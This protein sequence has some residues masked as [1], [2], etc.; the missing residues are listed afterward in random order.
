MNKS[1]VL[2]LWLFSLCIMFAT[3]VMAEVAKKPSKDARHD[4]AITAAESL[5]VEENTFDASVQKK[6]PKTLLNLSQLLK[7]EGDELAWDFQQF[8]YL[9]LLK[10]PIATSGR[11]DVALNGKDIAVN[12]LVK[13]PV[14]S[15]FRIKDGKVKQKK[16]GK[17]KGLSATE[18]P[19]FVF[20][21]KIMNQA[22]LGDFT[23][24]SEHFNIY[25]LPRDQS[26]WSIGLKPKDPES[27]LADMIHYI[28]LDGVSAGSESAALTQIM[29]MDVRGEPSL[30]AL[31]VAKSL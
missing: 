31:S 6:W 19:A 1:N 14:K 16:N 26:T 29:I 18:Q 30:I 7:P 27:Q 20:I 13:K 5:F 12:W 11:L 21:S 2:N 10:R 24:L 23:G 25:F 9:K 3:G 15:E 28:A 4:A 22:L 17:W 8:R